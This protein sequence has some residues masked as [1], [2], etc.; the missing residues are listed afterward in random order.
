MSGKWTWKT[1][2]QQLHLNCVGIWR[3]PERDGV[4]AAEDSSSVRPPRTR[5]IINNITIW[6]AQ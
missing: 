4:E 1:K 2:I 3:R 5:I 6:S